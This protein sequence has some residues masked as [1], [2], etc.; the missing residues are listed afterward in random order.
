MWDASVW[1]PRL[2]RE[3]A[4]ARAVT[5]ARSP[6]MGIYAAADL[7]AVCGR[8]R[9]ARWDPTLAVSALERDFVVDERRERSTGSICKY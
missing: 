8:P 4:A 6:K 7:G 5:V 3:C 1:V 9:L 2:L